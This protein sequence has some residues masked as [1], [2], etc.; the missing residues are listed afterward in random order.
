MVQ[1]DR[2]VGEVDWLKPGPSAGKAMVEE[3]IDQR[4]KEFGEKRNDP[5]VAA[6]SNLSPYFHFGQLSAQAV[7][8][9]LKQV[10]R[11]HESVQVRGPT[12]KHPDGRDGT[13]PYG[14][15]TAPLSIHL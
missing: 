14:T 11:Y 2:S 13:H 9:R 8:L 7:V 12:V 5:N 6:L 3:F 10:K 15:R 1:I 4:L